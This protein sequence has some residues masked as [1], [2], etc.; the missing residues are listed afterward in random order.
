[1][2]RFKKQEIPLPQPVD[3]PVRTINYLAPKTNENDGVTTEISYKALCTQ[4]SGIALYSSDKT[5][6]LPEAKTCVTPGEE[7]LSIS[8]KVQTSRPERYSERL[9]PRYIEGLEKGLSDII[10]RFNFR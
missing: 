2:F 8:L 6:V 9:D 7:D 1:M 10:N 4:L 5:Y 3:N